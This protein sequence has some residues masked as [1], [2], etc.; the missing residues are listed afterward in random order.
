MSADSSFNSRLLSNQYQDTNTLA[1]IPA[2]VT[3]LG[4]RRLTE[5]RRLTHQLRP[6][7]IISR[8]KRPH[9]LLIR[10]DLNGNRP[11]IPPHA[12][13]AHARPYSRTGGVSP[14]YS[15]A[16]AHPERSPSRCRRNGWGERSSAP[17]RGAAGALLPARSSL[18]AAEGPALRGAGRGAEGIHQQAVLPFSVT[19]TGWK[20][21]Q[22]GT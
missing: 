1:A 14:F 10:Y 2:P 12:K 5:H 3:L 22:R 20:G 4:C 13:P 11:V 7:A 9:I 16:R 18:T 8:N 17:E 15:P 21:G 19:W 6:Q